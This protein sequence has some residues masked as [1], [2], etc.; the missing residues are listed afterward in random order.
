MW[1]ESWMRVQRDA[2]RGEAIYFVLTETISAGEAIVGEVAVAGIDPNSG[3]GEL[4][5]WV[6]ARASAMV[7]QWAIAETSL[8]AFGAPYEV[9]RLIGPIAVANRAP[10]R[11]AA[12][13]GYEKRAERRG[14][15]MYGGTPADHALW[16]LEN[17][18]AN[19]MRLRDV[20]A[21]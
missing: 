4:S 8:R 5:I 1:V 11:L 14:L 17:T 9:P 20:V 7:A 16:V 6:S 18:E 19:R 3:S 10:A 15:R 12:N 21:R 2:K 13:L